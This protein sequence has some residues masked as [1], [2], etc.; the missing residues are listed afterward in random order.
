M[1]SQFGRRA[2]HKNA[3]GG[4]VVADKGSVP[5]GYEVAANTMTV[6]I[7]GRFLRAG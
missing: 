7:S 3:L 6:A 2:A 4:P 5:G 1:P